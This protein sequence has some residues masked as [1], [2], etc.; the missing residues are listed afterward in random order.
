MLLNY[1]PSSVLYIIGTGPTANELSTWISTEANVTTITK[2]DFMNLPINSQCLLGFQTIDYRINF[3][4]NSIVN[5]HKWPTYI[6]PS[7]VVTSID[8][9]GIGTTIGPTTSIGDKVF[10]GN[11]CSI[12]PLVSIGHGGQI[13]NNCV[14]SPG[15]LSEARLLSATMFI[16]DSLVQ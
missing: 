6:H 7:A 3:L 1:D 16:L 8:Q 12:G 13:G 5:Q 9:I 10:L 15:L 14:V 2:E 4:Q 11:F